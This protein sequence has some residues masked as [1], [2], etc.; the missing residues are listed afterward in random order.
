[1]LHKFIR[2]YYILFNLFRV[3]NLI[4]L[5][6]VFQVPYIAPW[7]ISQECTALIARFRSHADRT[8]VWKSKTRLNGT[9]LTLS[10]NFKMAVKGD[11]VAVKGDQ[12]YIDA[13]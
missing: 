1:M 10:G 4:Q 6:D 11:Q 5:Y 7:Y 13:L 9:G 2:V 8:L 3:N 12:H